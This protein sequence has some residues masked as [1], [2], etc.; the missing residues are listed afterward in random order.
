MITI[1][2]VNEF[3]PVAG[4]LELGMVDD[5]IAE[6]E[7]VPSTKKKTERYS[8]LLLAAQMMQQDWNKAAETARI[9]CKMSPKSGI[10]YIHGA[11]S[12]HEIGDTQAALQLLMQGPKSLLSDPLYHYNSA[13]YHAILGNTPPAINFLKKAIELDADLWMVAQED[14]DLKNIIDLDDY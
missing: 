7:Q 5:A 12:L 11:F 4:Y 3:E 14:D 1:E 6:L 10:Y 8:E 2:P 9:L 13:C